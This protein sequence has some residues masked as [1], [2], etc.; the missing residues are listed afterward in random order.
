M[1]LGGDGGHVPR[2]DGQDVHV[3]GAEE[4]GLIG[5]DGALRQTRGW[6]SL[7]GGGC[8]S[9]RLMVQCA[10]D[11]GSGGGETR[12]LIFYFF[13][14]RGWVRMWMGTSYF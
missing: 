5:R 13:R 7:I 10:A 12:F 6:S 14:L 11:V 4:E 3:P 9:T 1:K 8:Q 2:P